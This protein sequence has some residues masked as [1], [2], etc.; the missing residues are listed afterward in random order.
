MKGVGFEKKPSEWPRTPSV[1]S[2]IER[3]GE[4]SNFEYRLVDEHLLPSNK[5]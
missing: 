5:A 3:E 1:L 4:I 2:V